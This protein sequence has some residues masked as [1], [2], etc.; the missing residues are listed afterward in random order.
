LG[1]VYTRKGADGGRRIDCMKRKGC[2]KKK[3]LKEEKW[4]AKRIWK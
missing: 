3:Q 1:S 2:E 4:D